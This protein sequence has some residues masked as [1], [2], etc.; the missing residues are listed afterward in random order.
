MRLT[1]ASVAL[2]PRSAWEAVDL[3]LLMA[4]RYSGLLLASQALVTLPLFAL[5]SL[6]FWQYPVSAGMIIWWIKP[7]LERLP[8][9]ILSLALFGQPPSLRQALK[10]LPKLLW[11]QLFASLLWRRFSLWRSFAQPVSQLEGLSGKARS[12]RLRV[13]GQKDSATASGLTI[14]G[15]HIELVL[16]LGLLGLIFLLLPRQVLNL[17]ELLNLKN[18]LLDPQDDLLLYHLS[19]LTYVLV[20][21]IWQPIYAACGFTLYLNRRTHLEGWDIEL[22]FRALRQRKTGSAYAL[23]LLPILLLTCSLPTPALA[24]NRAGSSELGPESPR[25]LQQPLSSQGAQERIKALL[26]APPFTNRKTVT[27]WKR[28]KEGQLDNGWH[29]LKNGLRWLNDLAAVLSFYLQILLW[30]LVITVLTL[31]L[32]RGRHWLKTLL[33]PDWRKKTKSAAPPVLFGL[34]VSPQSL[35]DDLWHCSTAHCLAACC[36]N[37]ICR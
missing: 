1:E 9:H 17:D 16:W 32:W 14:L 2:R 25:L 26:D 8:L 35:P 30:A 6:C 33:K 23:L 15:V 34:A 28:D 22:K 12:E 7:L 10:A 19:N 3:G 20:L 13:L 18:W 21:I 24:Q 36:T 4:Q 37:L 5:I 11:P 29:R 27:E 31:L